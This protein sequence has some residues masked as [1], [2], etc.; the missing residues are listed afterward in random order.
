MSSEYIEHLPLIIGAQKEEA[1][2]TEN[3]VKPTTKR[4]GSHVRNNPFLLGHPVATE[5]NHRRGRVDAGD[6]PTVL[7]DIVRDRHS[8]PATKIENSCTLGQ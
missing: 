4:Y 1:V 3:S 7:H 5:R 6:M 2:P 8:R